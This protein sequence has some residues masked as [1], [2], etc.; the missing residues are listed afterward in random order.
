MAVAE[1]TPFA[2]EADEKLLNETDA[3]GCQIT[4]MLGTGLPAASSTR[5][6]SDDNGAPG[7]PD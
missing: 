2:S 1:T 7:D 4:G 6:T 5:A 3:E